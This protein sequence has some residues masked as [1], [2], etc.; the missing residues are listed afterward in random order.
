VWRI[1][2]VN[3]RH[4]GTGTAYVSP[5]SFDPYLPY[6][7]HISWVAAGPGAAQYFVKLVKSVEI[8]ETFPLRVAARLTLKQGYDLATV[9]EELFT[10]LNDHIKTIGVNGIVYLA[11]I[12]RII[13]ANEGVKYAD[14]LYMTLTCRIYRGP[15]ADNADIIP[16]NGSG[17]YD[18]TSATVLDIVWASLS[19]L[20]TTP[21]TRSV[22]YLWLSGT[23]QGV[24]Y[25]D[26][27]PGAPGPEPPVN[28]PYWVKCHVKA[29]IT[30]P[31]DCLV[32]LDGCDFTI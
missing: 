19:K 15:V 25:I 17:R 12:F 4:D 3:L 7:N 31:I 23:T 14:G 24:R 21:Y 32:V 2:W 27:S 9:S 6:D 20:G 11:D 13:T 16:I 18:D 26:W 28:N 5:G 8:A 22:D 29:D 30:P 10:A 1:D